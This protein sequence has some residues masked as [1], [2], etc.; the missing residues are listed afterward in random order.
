VKGDVKAG[1]I[2]KN[3]NRT[4]A[5]GLKVKS[6]IKAGALSKNRNQGVVRGAKVKSHIRAG[7]GPALEIPSMFLI[8]LCA[9]S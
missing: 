3:H 1:G 6:E 5:R 9:E 7:R 4:P 2:T 8:L